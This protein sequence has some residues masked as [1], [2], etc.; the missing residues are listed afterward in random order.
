MLSPL[1]PHTAARGGCSG[2]L[3]LPAELPRESLNEGQPR[4]SALNGLQL[5][6]RAVVFHIEKK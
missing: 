4:R 5:E 1:K 3:K 6:A 2:H